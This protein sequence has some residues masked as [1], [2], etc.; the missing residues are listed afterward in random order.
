MSSPPAARKNVDDMR[1]FILRAAFEIFAKEGASGVTMRAIA[2]RIGYSPAAIYRYFPKKRAIF[3]ALSEQGFTKFNVAMAP[4]YAIGDLR[5]KLLAGARGYIRFALENSVDYELMFHLSGPV[6]P[7]GDLNDDAPPRRAF[8]MLLGLV[9]ECMAAGIAP[10]GDPLPAALSLWSTLHGF[11]SL[12]VRG[13]LA[14]L[15]PEGD[16]DQLVE[17]VVAFTMRNV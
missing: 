7:E 16:L 1:G 15:R 3:H 14:S 2:K 9:G 10:Q 11:A 8:N 6:R 17:A 5:E 4:Y 12:L 13:K